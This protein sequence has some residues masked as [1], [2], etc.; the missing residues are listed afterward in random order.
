[1]SNSSHT[2]PRFVKIVSPLAIA[3][4]LAACGG[5]GSTFGGGGDGGGTKTEG[6]KPIVKVHSLDLKA[7]LNQLAMDGQ[8]IIKAIA[9]DDTNNVIKD[10]SFSFTVD[11]E[12]TLDAEGESAVLTAGGAQVGD[13]L[14]VTVTSGE[15][16]QQV[17]IEVVEQ[18]S[19][20]GGA[21]VDSIAIGADSLELLS[22]GSKPV[23][24]T[25]I[26][27]NETNNVIRDAVFSF[28][29]DSTATLEVNGNTAVLTPNGA[30]G[31]LTV[32]VTSG[33]VS[34]TIN[35]EVVDSLTQAESA[36]KIGALDGVN[37]REGELEIVDDNLKAGGKTTIKVS[38]VDSK[39]N[40]EL[41]SE[42]TTV[43][44]NSS[45]IANNLASISDVV[46][47]A[48]VASV[49]YEAKGCSGVDS[50]TATAIVDGKTIKAISDVTVAAPTIG[51]I[52]FNTAEPANI[53][54]QGMGLDEVAAVSFT[55]L[56]TEG[57][58]VINHE[59]NFA[60]SNN[61]G[62]AYLTSTSAKTD[63][64]GNVVARV[65]SGTKATTIKVIASVDTGTKI[66]KTESRGLVISTGVADEDSF[67]LSLEYLN[68]E[69]FSYDGVVSKVYVQAADHFNNPVPEG[70]AV[71]FSTEA[72]SITSSC[73]T[74]SKGS[75]S[76][77]WKSGGVRPDDGRSTITG[78]IQG[79]ESFTDLND[80]GLFDETENFTDLNGDGKYNGLLCQ[81]SNSLC[82]DIK[83]VKINKTIDIVM[84]GSSARIHATIDGERNLISG[85]SATFEVFK[86]ATGSFAFDLTDYRGQPLP[87]GSTVSVSIPATGSDEPAHTLIS[88][89]SFTI[90]NTRNQNPIQYPVIVKDEGTGLSSVLK[91]TVTTPKGNISTA[92]VNLIE[93]GTQQEPELADSIILTATS[94]QLLSDG[95]LPVTFNARVRDADKIELTG[96]FV[97]FSLT[98]NGTLIPLGGN[99]VSL[100][101][102]NAT[103]GDTLTVSA[104]IKKSD[105]SLVQANDIVVNVVDKLQESQADS[106]ELSASTRQLFSD[107]SSPVVLSAIVKDKNNNPIDSETVIFSVDNNATITPLESS[108][109]VKTA[110]LTPGLNHP[111][112]RLL[113]VSATVG[114]LQQTLQVEVV[115]T[116]LSVEGP[117]SIAINKPTEYTF[118]LQDS[119]DKPIAY[120]DITV[121]STSGHTITPVSGT[122]F[123]TDAN[124]ELTVTLE[125]SSG[126]IDTLT[127]TAMGASVTQ[128]V[129][130][131]G[132]DFTLAST[133]SDIDLGAPETI[134]VEWLQDTL[135]M[136]GETIAIR[137][138]RGTLSAS[139]VV[140]D[141]SGQATFDISSN[142]AGSATITAETSGG[143][144]TTLSREFV[145][146]TPE[147]LS[148][149]ASPSLIAPNGTSTVITKVRDANDNPVKGVKVNFNLTDAVNG[150][151]S[152]SLAVTDSLGRAEVVYTAGD[153][154][155]SLDGVQ[156]NTYLQDYPTITDLV[157]LTVGSD[158]LRIVLGSDETLADSGV[159]YTKTFG[160]IVTDSAG[161][162]IKDHKVDFT[163]K[164]TDYIKGFM[165]LADIDGDLTPDIW[166]QEITTL[167][168]SSSCP[169]EDLD[170]DGQLDSGEDDN[171]NNKLDP[172]QAAT[173][174]GTGTT[175]EQGKLT[176]Q[177]VYPQSEALWSIQRLTATTVVDG[178]ETVENTTFTLPMTADDY[179]KVDE[180]LPNQVSPY[181]TAAVCT[182][183]N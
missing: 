161:N 120:K 150:T 11:N 39:N 132:N 80:N 74:D 143:L 55:V 61:L 155:S 84:S 31:T 98:G 23:T 47:N 101:P 10:A 114:S 79:E 43:T 32:T 82:S 157:T 85:G 170:N 166:A 158:A 154:S 14:T 95:S 145:A 2:V 12:A 142:A 180:G 50:V 100:V 105:G 30:T 64:S 27:K 88:D 164:A 146:T 53:G 4:A 134:T 22:D 76:V 179:N 73:F 172:T 69:A 136:V 173:V 18:L 96:V 97:D 24:V 5:G 44:F 59:V 125:A 135:P 176:V 92:Y 137:T 1:M 6:E 81:T 9:K 110:E 103:A 169:S 45:C 58:P 62:G 159:F 33:E 40:N 149:Q 91:I 121:T 178:T 163:I 35:I 86:N 113:T 131:S 16:S 67:S 13:I 151:L 174:T 177:V 175:D 28:S 144:T 17:L 140:T 15:K 139:S 75:C 116:H 54:L 57:N 21:K 138:T 104:S 77:E 20:E 106:L 26:A 60:L 78:S 71:Y 160:V 93:K 46:F 29:V 36:I 56:D 117:A 94:T 107:G 37:F 167:P 182:D 127:A 87:Q 126:G 63:A 124:G 66:I 34:K 99:Q 49:T 65:N 108:G 123:T 72:G 133:N 8:V 51:S 147:Y 19:S 7:D 153:S 48:G 129:E 122:A 90:P 83:T 52:S 152:N 42:P 41:Y 181:G 141:A 102:A 115:G 25:A 171:G 128:D 38:L 130:I 119:G 3:I 111:E 89:A 183:A 162:P 109:A 112:N 70:T 118:K 148:T 165:Y 68:P 156:I 168:G